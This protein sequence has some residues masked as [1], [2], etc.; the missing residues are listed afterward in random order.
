VLNFPV[1]CEF[2]DKLYTFTTGTKAEKVFSLKTIIYKRMRNSLTAD[3][4]LE[5]MKISL[6]GKELTD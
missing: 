5:L 3:H 4:I 6:V 2:V 1:F